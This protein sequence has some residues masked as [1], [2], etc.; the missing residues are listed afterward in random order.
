MDDGLGLVLINRIK[1]EISR[2]Y[3]VERDAIKTIHT[4]LGTV[5]FEFENEE[6]ENKTVLKDSDI[7]D[8]VKTIL[9]GKY[10][11]HSVQPYFQRVD[12]KGAEQMELFNL[13]GFACMINQKD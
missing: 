10:I 11:C 3:N 1:S 12:A 5:V 9:E 13:V 2:Q 8:I 4:L 7:C 6:T